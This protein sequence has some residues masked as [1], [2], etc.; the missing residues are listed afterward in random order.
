MADSR[1][2]DSILTVDEPGSPGDLQPAEMQAFVPELVDLNRRWLE[3]RRDPAL[4]ADEFYV[5]KLAN[6]AP[7]EPYELALATAIT[8]RYPV[9]ATHIVEIGSGWGGLAILLARL[10]FSVTAYEGN[11]ARY[12]GCSWHIGEQTRTYPIL[13]QRLQLAGQGLFPEVFSDAHLAPG[14]LNVCIATNITSSYSAE[15]EGAM[16]AAAAAFDELILDLARF[17]VRRDTKAERDAFFEEVTARWFS[18]VERLI[19]DEPYEYWRFRSRSIA[20]RRSH[21]PAT[22]VRDHDLAT[23]APAA[24]EAGQRQP[25]SQ[26]PQ[27]SPPRLGTNSWTTRMRRRDLFRT[28]SD[29]QIDPLKTIPE[30][31]AVFAK[32]LEKP[33][34]D[35]QVLRDLKALLALVDSVSLD[36]LRARHAKGMRT[37]DAVSGYKYLDFVFY[38]LQKLLLAYELGLDRGP[39]RRV[40]DIGTAGGHFPFVCRFFGHEVVG[41]DIE[42]PLYEGIAGCLGVE[43]TIAR[44]EAYRP[45]P[46]LGGRFDLITACNTTFNQKWVEQINQSAYWRPAEWQFFLNDLVSNQLRYPGEL[47]LQINRELYGNAEGAER[48]VRTRDILMRAA[49][50][51]ATIS[52]GSGMIRMKFTAPRVIRLE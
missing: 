51:G 29:R 27:P 24:G 36:A 38:T 52:H 19:A 30:Q 5:A 43:R 1:P 26:H 39:P 49:R 35:G 15:H 46:D 37:A 42:S 31:L 23:P 40:L 18:P 47:Y 2:F 50:N 20:G 44:V 41:I 28:I 14:K 10:G 21:Q 17:G 32:V 33:W 34:W 12:A 6:H 3:R 8:E 11:S 7:L 13:R 25:P 48:L 9:D 45:L 16:I 4:P 22:P